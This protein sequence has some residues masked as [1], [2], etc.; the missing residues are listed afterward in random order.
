MIEVTESAQSEFKRI[1][2]QEGS[3]S[4]GIRLGVKG[5]GCSGY[6]YVMDFVK[7]P[8]DNDTVFNQEKTP[9]YIDPKSLNLIDGI[10]IDFTSDM[11]NRGFKFKN[12]NATQACGCGTSF[13]V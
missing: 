7:D 11:L 4:M 8:K 5:G 10:V 9:I 13:A 12:P 6:S 3:S 2:T 1:M